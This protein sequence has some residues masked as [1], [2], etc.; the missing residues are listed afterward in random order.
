MKNFYYGSQTINNQDI[1]VVSQTLKSRLITQGPNLVKFENNLLKYF[2]SKYCLAVS[3]GTAALH[4]SVL[5]LNAKKN[6]IIITTP[7]TFLAS[8]ACI[9]YSNC[10]IVLVDINLSNFTIDVEKLEKK[11]VEL[12]KNKKKIK[13]LIAVDY[14]GYPCNWKKLKNLSQKFNFFLINDNCHALGSKYFNSKQYAQKYADIVTQSFHPV[15]AITTGEGGAVFTNSKKIYNKIKLLRSHHIDR[16]KNN[17]GEWY[18]KVE[19][20]G[21][22]YRLTDFQASLGISQLKKLDIFIKKR[23][24]IA[25]FYHKYFGKFSQF[26]SIDCKNKNCKN[27]YHLFPLLFDFKKNK[28]SKNSF[29]TKMKK[30]GINLQV[31]YVPIFYLKAFKKRVTNLKDNFQNSKKFYENSFSIPIYPNLNQ[32][33][34]NFISKNIIKHLVK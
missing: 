17:I 28:V 31:H 24:K 7:I 1:K 4:L 3:S 11:L 25:K 18:Y 27:S 13:A 22:N 19:N 29:F 10:K 34:L 26:K 16:S 30:I 20:L 2:G 15:K 14:G 23:Q 12:K 8:A 32:R 21:F 6:D 5:S 9:A 33:D